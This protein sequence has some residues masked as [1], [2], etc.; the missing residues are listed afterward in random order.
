[1]IYHDEW[2]TSTENLSSFKSTCQLINDSLCFLTDGQFGAYMQVN[3]QND[4]P[5]TIEIES[6]P[7]VQV[8]VQLQ[9]L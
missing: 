4:G 9:Q 2:E 7:Q 6:P 1:M 3:I 8:R 5:V